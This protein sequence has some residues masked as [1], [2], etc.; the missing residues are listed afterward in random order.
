MP[1]KLQLLSELAENTAKGLTSS[2]EDWTGFLTTVGRLYKY[3]YHEQLMIYAQRPDATACAEYDLWNNTMNRYVRRG[4]KGIALL[5]PSGDTLKL[6]YVFDVSDT[7][8][9]ENSRNPF[10]WNMQDYHKE[11][12]LEMLTDKF[13]VKNNTLSDAF[14]NIARNMSKE[15]YDNNTSDIRYLIE[16]SYLEEYDEDNIRKTFEDAAT[17]STAYTLMKR[18]GLNTE[19]YFAH[20]DFLNIFD[21]N[22]ADTVALLGTAVSEQSEQ[23]FRQISL[24]IIKVE[25]ERSEEHE[26]N[27][28][29]QERGLSDTRPYID[30]TI[31]QQGTEFIGQIRKN[32]E[33]ISSGEQE[34]IIPLPSPIREA[35]SPPNGNRPDSQ[36]KARTNYEGFAENADP[37]GQDDTSDGMGGLHEQPESTGRGNGTDGINIQ[38]TLFPTEQEQIQKITENL[39]FDKPFSHSV[40]SMSQ[41]M[42]D[43][44]LR[45]GSNNNS[46]L[47][48]ILS[49]YQKD[50][51]IE[52]KAD[53]LQKEYQGGKGLYIEGQ[54][55]SIWF[56]TDGIHIAKGE[57]A[58][59]SP[60]KE[61]ISWTDVAETIEKLLEDG[62]YVT[63]DILGA[64][65]K[66]ERQQLAETF[67]Y[68][69][70][71]C[72]DKAREE[73]FKEEIFQGGFPDSTNRISQLLIN[74]KERASFIDL[75]QSFNAAY[76]QD[77]TIL[78]FHFHKPQKLLS[79]FME[80]DLPI[81]EFSSTLSNIDDFTMFITQDEVD[82]ELT[83]GSG[84]K[85]GKYRIYDYFT[86]SYSPKEKEDF[87]KQEYGIGG[88]SHA[89][90][91]ADNSNQM[92][93]GKGILYSRRVSDDKLLLNWSRV[94]KR[95]DY[96]ISI[97]RYMTT[98]EKER[99]EELQQERAGIIETPPVSDA[100]VDERETIEQPTLIINLEEGLKQE[101]TN[102]IPYSKGDTVLLENGTPFLVEEITDYHVTLR[103]PSLL[104][105]ILRA[106][107]RESFLRLI[108][109]YPQSQLPQEKAEN[110]RIADEYLGEGSKRDKFTR[111]VAAITTL[112][113]IEKER[114]PATKEEQ[115]TLSH[116]VGWGGLSE[117]FDKDN[118]SFSGEFAQLKSL[119]SDD[120]YSMARASTLNAHYTSPT[121]IKA[122]YSA[123]EHMG[124]STGNILEPACGIGHFFGM[125][126]D[127]MKGSNLY[128]VE[129]DSITGRI[130]K[131]LYPNANISITGFEKTELPD[132]FFDLAIGNVPFGNYKLSEKR[133]DNNNFL[134]H[135]HFF[136]KALDK[137]RPGGVVAFI[138]SKGT[139]D[140]QSSDVRRYLA[141]RAELLG[142]IR[143]PN[144]AFLKNAGTEV[145][146]DII[147]LQKRD[148]PIDMDRD[149]IH[150]DT[151][152]DGITLNSYFA[153]QPEMI[154]GTMEMKSGQFG[155]ES[156]CTP[157]PHAE[158]SEQLKSAILNIE[159]N[160]SEIELPDMEVSS[161]S[162]V[163]ADPSV[164][165]FSY[166]LL[167]GEVYYRENS[168]MVKPDLNQTAKE[169]ITGLV[170]LRECV[171]NLIS[172]QLEDYSEETIREEQESLNLLY[173]NFTEK[174]GLINS[175]GNSLAFSDDNSYY[176]LCSL[177]DVDENG[178]LKA[179]ADM[180]NKR[181]I[182]KRVTINSVDTASEASTIHS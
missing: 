19:G 11:P 168:R 34:A 142:A 102:H 56:H 61:V 160:I 103:D 30:T 46:S 25:R 135:D 70:Q 78:R 166:T 178:N 152:E 87:I 122:I 167:D 151:N 139:M 148:R 58:L 66:F 42:I 69:H 113:T 51:S 48:K 31:K 133:Y 146:S 118:S 182:K 95:I 86:G 171:G 88:K 127:S 16:N 29:Q 128:G 123:V 50:K 131:Q 91:G 125:L 76:E 32:E 174:Y 157:L 81:R 164:K 179:K 65:D 177:E 181:T 137:V 170:E 33:T 57:T 38:L 84:I 175:R 99:F 71:D 165:N 108:E 143:L 3:P 59:Y 106:E 147:F 1:T 68:L 47:L 62:Q 126:P 22:T 119:L 97:N 156:T 7:V 158:L 14:Y 176:L 124:F 121:V 44:I 73:F 54:K 5:D 85:N 82:K 74:P 98:E 39:R 80:L 20:E 149:W 77:P 112:Q 105:P 114:R 101:E 41:N 120:E 132:S 115:E 17:V 12:I 37:T 43:S 129:L 134:I 155:M 154:L 169:R 75:L 18:C 27:H 144:N 72:S 89:L 52:E 180:F 107:S 49:F 141:Q 161:S 24:T 138:T 8:G 83:S 96:L 63:Q 100:I 111:N 116:Y 104:Y 109:L 172:Y 163:P 26:R 145:T 10:L 162:S 35:V 2:F 140:K 79:G 15:Y 153:N 55:I 94:A 36:Q 150:L 117:V 92:H 4:S 136:A 173:D 159:G 130:A 45:T 93:D 9:R 53:F 64:V 110:F 67:W 6:K 23:I 40:F 21:F 13:D 28:L 60:S 90:S